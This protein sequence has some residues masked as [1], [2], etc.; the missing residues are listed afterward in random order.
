MKDKRT[1]TKL[2]EHGEDMSHEN[3]RKHSNAD[4]ST[5][6]LSFL[7]EQ[8]KEEIWKFK[9]KEMEWIKTQNQLEGNRKIVE[10]LSVLMIDLKKRIDELENSLSIALEINDRYQR[11]KASLKKEVDRLEEENNNI[12]LIDSSHQELNGKLQKQLREVEGEISI[13]KGIGNNSPEM[14]TLQLENKH[15][16]EQVDALRTQ[17]TKAGF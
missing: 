9:Q 2:K 10:E 4:R 5:G 16:K 1:Y 6:D 17:L 3:E 12:R 15:L 7:I 14:K 8:H 13:I 11:E